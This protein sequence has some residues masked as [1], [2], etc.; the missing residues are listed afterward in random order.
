VRSQ[1]Y[2]LD[3]VVVSLSLALQWYVLMVELGIHDPLGLAAA[4]SAAAI[5]EGL[6]PG[7]AKAA[8]AAEAVATIEELQ[9]IILFARCWRFIRVGHG[10]ANSM[11]DMMHAAKVSFSA[12]SH[13]YASHALHAL[14]RA[15][16]HLFLHGTMA[17]QLC[18]CLDLPSVLS[19][20]YAND[21]ATA[22]NGARAARGRD[23]GGHQ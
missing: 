3:F 9:S 18:A 21:R 20:G 19:G 12:T 6:T 11:H 7:E 16:L 2:I 5:S 4:A 15:S 23:S 13:A 1:G 10:I 8:A 14:Q 17:D 22:A